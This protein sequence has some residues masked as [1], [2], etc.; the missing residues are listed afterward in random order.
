MRCKPD[1]LHHFCE[2]Q[3]T[4]CFFHFSGLPGCRMAFDASEW[5]GKF[6]RIQCQR[7]KESSSRRKRQV[8]LCRKTAT[9]KVISKVMA[10][11]FLK[12]EGRGTF[13][14]AKNWRKR[15]G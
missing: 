6:D 10:K 12:I 9:V 2:L 4:N 8:F 7:S 14:G 11:T 13:V 3:G 1:D 15:D 5:N